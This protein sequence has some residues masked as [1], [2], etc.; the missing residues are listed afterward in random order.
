M[1]RST[2]VDG[3]DSFDNGGQKE[4]P[5]HDATVGPY[6]MD[7]FEVTVG[8][9]RAFLNQYDTWRKE[10]P[11][12]GSGKIPGVEGSG[13]KKEWNGFLP[14]SS[15]AFANALAASA[16]NHTWTDEVGSSENHPIN[17]I[18]WYEAYAFCIWDGGRLPTE[19]EWEYAAAGG[20]NNFR[21]PWGPGS[22]TSSLAN[23]LS[24]AHT[25]KKDVGSY[26]DGR[27]R[28]GQY[29]L[30]GSVAE[31]VL[32][33]L[34]DYDDGPCAPC[35]QQDDSSLRVVRGGSW[36]SNASG[37]RCAARLGMEASRNYETVGFRCVRD[38]PDE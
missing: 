27:G 26:P 16:Q 17:S 9:F 22:P 8:R 15:K 10:H 3:T 4:I 21:Y 29:D 13:W 32:D 5:E 7:M 28:F 2:E 30:A 6:Y 34:V 12:A 20:S 25:P 37:L 18:T 19:A 38:I 33:N 1:G 31:W 24:S 14:A 23:Y 11:V 36:A 35:F